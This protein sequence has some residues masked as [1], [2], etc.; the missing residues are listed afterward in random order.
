MAGEAGLPHLPPPAGVT[1]GFQGRDSNARDELALSSDAGSRGCRQSI[2]GQGASLYFRRMPERSGAARR[3]LLAVFV[4][5]GGVVLTATPAL[6]LGGSG[7]SPLVPDGRSENGHRIYE[8]YTY[9]ISPFAIFVFLLVEILLLLIIIRFRRR[10]QASDYKPPQ[11]HGNR[12]FEIGWTIVPFLILCVIGY[13]SFV[14]L[15][16]DF[17]RPADSVTDLDITVSAHQF[18]WIYTYPEGFKVTSEGLTATPLVIPT[19]KLVRLRLQSTDVIHSYWV[20]DLTGKT[21][22]VP[23][24]DNYTWLKVGQP[25]KWRGECA[26]LCGTGHYT[27]QISVQAMAPDDYQAW[28]ADQVTK[29]KATPSPSAASSPAAGASPAPGA[30]PSPST[31][32]SASPS[33]KPSVSPSASP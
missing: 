22:T 32:G 7:L 29:S 28:V 24:Y 12:W 2:V 5:V 23:G 19:G 30:S 16:K 25:G 21:D 26:E 6:A 10:T 13:A 15:Q 11:W 1:L 20:V 14:E 4:G 3:L 31:A 17:V 27:M 33:A 8:L 9:L 18:G